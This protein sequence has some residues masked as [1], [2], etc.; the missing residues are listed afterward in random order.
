MTHRSPMT[1]Y[2]QQQW[3]N[4]GATVPAAKRVA[5]PPQQQNRAA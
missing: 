1:L 5:P 2:L 3:H 4:D